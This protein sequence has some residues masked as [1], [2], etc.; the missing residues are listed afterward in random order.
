VTFAG[1]A[2]TALM[3]T[4]TGCRDGA[5]V[6]ENEV[7]SDAA[8]DAAVTGT[9]P[10]EISGRW[11]G[12]DDFPGA[13]ATTRDGLVSVPRHGTRHLPWNDGHVHWCSGGVAK[14]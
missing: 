10:D 5:A 1:T 11:L 2:P 8:N 12:D 6:G 4:A 7:G 9:V 3:T 13:A 14:R